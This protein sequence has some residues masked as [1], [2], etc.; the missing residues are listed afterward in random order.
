LAAPSH[1][2][3]QNE[4]RSGAFMQVLVLLLL[5]I[6]ANI[7]FAQSPGKELHF[8]EAGSGAIFLRSAFAHGYRHGYEEGYHLGNIDINMGRHARAKLSDVK[9]G[10]SRYLPEFGPR[11]SFESGFQEGLKA[12]Y[13][14]GYVGRSFRAVENLR[15]IALAL[16]TKPMSSDPNNTYFDQGLASG[17]DSGLDLAQK[18]DPAAGKL[19]VR[20]IGCGQFHPARQQD[21][22]AEASFCDGYR[23]GY[24]LGHADG[25]VLRP[26]AASLAARK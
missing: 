11:K 1:L 20:F 3:S 16:D 18:D 8:T 13:A 6:L 14:D 24:V 17:Y 26:E 21:L 23:R 4:L 25:I 15:F 5:L 19:D 2:N 7:S 12:G 10:S 9:G 22:A